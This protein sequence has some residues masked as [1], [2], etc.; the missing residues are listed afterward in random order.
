MK[1]L[2]YVCSVLWLVLL[3]QFIIKGNQN[4]E[5]TVVAAME[6]IPFTGMETCI[7][8]SGR[9]PEYLNE[10]QQQKLLTALA[11]E[12]GVY[13][14][15][16]LE[17]EKKQNGTV[18][19]FDKSG[20][21]GTVT[22]KFI[23]IEQSWMPECYLVI[24]VNIYD[25]VQYALEYRQKI[26]GLC[27]E[28]RVEGTVCMELTGTYGRQLS[29]DEK[30]QEELAMFAEFQ[31]EETEG[32]RDEKLYTVYGYTELIES[33]LKTGENNTNVNLAF[34]EDGQGNTVCHLGIP[35]LWQE[36]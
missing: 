10:N 16:T 31:A 2:L 26:Q 20:A 6:Q 32:N 14:D 13:T 29:M 23:A 4:D 8:V 35:I 18:T 15:Y 22:L 9:Y 12:L 17:T 33:V 27:N 28:Y 19:V 30:K 7:E 1:R 11:E 5:S 34:T 36:Y 21:N 3:G 24:D 25:T